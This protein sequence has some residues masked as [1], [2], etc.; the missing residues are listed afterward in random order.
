MCYKGA[1]TAYNRKGLKHVSTCK[2]K[3]VSVNQADYGHSTSS[4]HQNN[5]LEKNSTF[6]PLSQIKKN[7]YKGFVRRTCQPVGLAYT[8]ADGKQRERVD[9]V[10]A[11]V[12]DTLEHHHHQPQLHNT[13]GDRGIKPA[14]LDGNSRGSHT[15]KWWR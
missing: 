8:E 7:R 11:E 5:S 4:V 6:K 3:Q 1:I 13:G 2:C 10:H 14:C 12:E 15:Y 9:N